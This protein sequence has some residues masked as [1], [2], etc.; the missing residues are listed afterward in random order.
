AELGVS[1]HLWQGFAVSLL[2]GSGALSAFLI[3]RRRARVVTIYG[4]SALAVGTLLTLVA[5]STS[6]LVGYFVAVAVAGS[7]FG[8]ACFGV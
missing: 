5:L 2:A 8:T 3:R 7:G 6:S 4:T 1:A